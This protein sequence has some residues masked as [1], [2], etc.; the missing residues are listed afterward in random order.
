MST[1]RKSI[2]RRWETQVGIGV[3]VACFAV[4]GVFLGLKIGSGKPDKAIKTQQAE[5]ASIVKKAPRAKAARPAEVVLKVDERTL[6]IPDLGGP[7]REVSD[8]PPEAYGEGEPVEAEDALV[9]YKS[10]RLKAVRHGRSSVVE[11]LSERRQETVFE[12]PPAIASSS[13]E[14]VAA[15]DMGVSGTAV[16]EDAVTSA[17]SGVEDKVAAAFPRAHKVRPSDTL[18]DIS[19]E[20][21][22]TVSKWNLIYETNGLSNRDILIVGQELVIPSLDSQAVPQQKPVVKKVSSSGRRGSLGVAHR[23]QRG[24]TLRKLAKAY[25]KDES[26]WKKISK[27]NKGALKGR[28]TLKPGEVLIIP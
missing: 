25:Y 21:Y 24:D 28:E 27:A 5:K 3:A 1:G 11:Y 17:E 6:G 14:M 18:M 20:Y 12:E 4:L 8:L 10:N 7:G 9:L 16:A 13:E 15:S 23:V 2:I 19:K 26:G 22:G